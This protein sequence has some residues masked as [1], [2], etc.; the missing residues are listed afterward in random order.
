M[1]RTVATISSGSLVSRQIGKASTP[2]N[3]LKSIALPS[4]T[5][6]AAR[7]PMSPSPSTAV[8]SVTT[9][10][11]L[12]LIVYWKALSGSSRIASQTRATPGRVGHREVVARLERVAVALLDLAAQV[13]QQRAVGGVDHLDIV[14][15]LH[16]GD[17]A[18]DVLV[19]RGIDGDVAQGVDAVDLHQVHGADGPARLAD[20]R[21]DLAQHPR[22][23]HDLQSQGDRVLGAGG[24]HGEGNTTRGNDAAGWKNRSDERLGGRRH[25]ARARSPDRGDG[26][27]RVVGRGGGRAMAA[28]VGG[29]GDAGPS[30]R[31][32]RRC[33]GRR[34]VLHA[35]AGRRSAG[36]QRGARR[37]AC[38]PAQP[39]PHA[40]A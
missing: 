35:H 9:A 40:A 24:G 34:R 36:P 39:A 26:G 33:A 4:M 29:G 20:R 14:Q 16:R 3:S 30:R 22:P 28:A 27:E 37:P 17:D 15:R 10:T 38:L 2:P 11:V 25:R 7:G 5:G 8:P 23:V 32:Q 13:Q 31:P 6:M 1:A 18:A 12:R 21:G 19:P